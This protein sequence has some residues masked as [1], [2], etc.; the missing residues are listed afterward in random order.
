MTYSDVH[1][2]TCFSSDSTTPIEAQLDRAIKRGMQHICI[3]DHQDYDYPP[4]HS[5]YLLSE[6]GDIEGYLDK[7][8]KTKERYADR[9]EMCIGIE[10]G[11]QPHLAERHNKEYLKYPFD[12]VIGSTHCFNGR[13]TEDQ[14][15][16]QG[17]P[18]DEAIHEYFQTELKNITVTD[19][20]DTIGHLDFV[21]RDVPGKNEGFS[22]QK[23]SEILDA[24]LKTAIEKGK[25]IELNTKSL[26]M[27]M[28]DSSPGADVFKRY[29]E[30]GGERVTLGSDAHFPARIGA[31]FDIAGE[32]LKASGFRY[33]CIYREHQPVFLLL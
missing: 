4:W 11:L 8:Q 33:Y 9:I 16:Y 24:I 20:F 13:D 25:A 6:T 15:L 14:T 5:T 1:I 19:G 32:I 29:R 18:K 2:H 22:Y 31:C 23:H 21:L 28:G 10:F 26:V 17:R 27:G 30:L 7:L 3:T 12:M